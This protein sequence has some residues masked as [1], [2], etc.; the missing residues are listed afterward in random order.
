MALALADFNA[1]TLPDVV[2]ASAGVG[3]QNGSVAVLLNN[4]FRPLSTIKGIAYVDANANGRQD[5]GENGL[6]GSTLFIDSNSNGQ[7]DRWETSTVTD[8][9]G[10]YDFGG[11]RP[12]GP[13][14]ITSDLAD[15]RLTRWSVIAPVGGRALHPQ[16][17]ARR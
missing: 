12:G 6:P 16:A 4:N 13:Y 10:N 9:L 1:D 14:T 7:Y 2:F 17:G 11:L 15:Q 5:P 3:T 8:S